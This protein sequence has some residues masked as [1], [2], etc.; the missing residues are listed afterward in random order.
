M[1]KNCN[2]NSLEVSKKNLDKLREIRNTGKLS[3]LNS[4]VGICSLGPNVKQDIPIPVWH[5]KKIPTRITLN[6]IPNIPTSKIIGTF[7]TADII[8]DGG[9]P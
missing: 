4:K 3:K 9:K 5:P 1:K 6:D 2:Y 7:D 8:I